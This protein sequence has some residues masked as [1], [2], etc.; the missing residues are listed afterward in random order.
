MNLCISSRVEAKQKHL[1]VKVYDDDGSAGRDAVGS[2][3]INLELVKEKGSS[4]EWVKLPKLFG[5]KSNGQVHV[6]MTFRPS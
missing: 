1:H 4:D 5:L 2:A 6:T 3:K